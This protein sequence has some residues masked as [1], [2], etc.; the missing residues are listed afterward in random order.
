MKRTYS[1]LIPLIFSVGSLLAQAQTMTPELLWSLGRVSPVGLNEAADSLYYRVSTPRVDSN[2]FEVVYY[3]VALSGGASSELTKAP[4][5]K[6]YSPDGEY[7]LYH[8]EVKVKRVTASDYYPELEESE[9]FIWDDL[10]YRHWDHNEEGA[11]QHV[12]Y[13]PVNGKTTQAVDIMSGEP[14]HCPQSPFGGPEDYLWSPDGG[15]ILYVAKKLSGAEYASSTNTD[16]YSYNLAS[17]KTRNLTEYNTGYDQAPSFSPQGHLSWLQMKREGYE[18][19]KNDIILRYLGEDYNLTQHW[20]ETVR[21]FYWAPSGDQ[22]YFT[23]A[24]EGTVQLFSLPVNLE[25]PLG[26]PV[27]QITEGDFDV[28]GLVDVHEKGLILTR[29][30]FNH[31]SEVFLYEPETAQWTGLTRVNDAIYDR[32]S[33][34]PVERH[35]MTTTDGKEMLSWVIYPPGFDPEKSYPTLLYCQG[36]P[37]GALSQFYSFRWNFQLMAAQGYIIVAPNRRGMP[38]FGVEWNEQISKDWGGQA[39]DDYLT[40]I[41][42]MAEKD[43]VDNERIG[44]IGASYGGYSVYQLAGLHEDRFKTFIAHAGVFNLESMYGTTEEIFFVNWEIGGP[45]WNRENTAAQRSYREFNPIR[46]VDKWDTP[47]LIIQGGKDYRVPMGQSQEAFQAARLQDIPSR[48]LLF[49]EENHWILSPQNGLVWQREFFRW[50]S[51]TL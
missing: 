14:Y 29:R 9:A 3:R 8:E 19:D 51:E 39:M 50:L 12:M 44:A 48:F 43:Y 36:G 22:I 30:D 38:G 35:L 24:K 42:A 37:Q 16:I 25:Q 17:G 46:N 7:V 6:K 31:A 11:F 40:A 2:D 4:D 23:A 28:T 32:I 34:S 18:S 10:A 26:Q 15:Q 47:I 20:D 49:P 21:S 13:R 5:N 41:D 1:L 27:E 45:Y 33:T